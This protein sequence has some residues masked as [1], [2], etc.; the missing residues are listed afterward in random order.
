[1]AKPPRLCYSARHSDNEKD[2]E[3]GSRPPEPPHGTS[4]APTLTPWKTFP[5]FF[6]NA[7]VPEDYTDY[8][9][10]AKARN[11]TADSAGSTDCED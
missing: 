11:A 4:T 3:I 2:T 1:M 8:V 9:A 10:E 6:F 7:I 5:A